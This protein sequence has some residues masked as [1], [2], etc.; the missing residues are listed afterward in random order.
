M[1]AI[2]KMK[3]IYNYAVFCRT[4]YIN[5]FCFTEKT[6]NLHFIGTCLSILPPS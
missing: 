6:Y 1:D 4:L 3:K 2:E 5:M